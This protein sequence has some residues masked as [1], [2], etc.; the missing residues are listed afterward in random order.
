MS[1]K[2]Q[3]YQLA[4]GSSC[5]IPLEEFKRGF[6][7]I[8]N[9]P[10]RKIVILST[11]AI[12]IFFGAKHHLLVGNYQGKKVRKEIHYDY[13]IFISNEWSYHQNR[14]GEY[15]TFQSE[16]LTLKKIKQLISLKNITTIKKLEVRNNEVLLAI[17]TFQDG[18][19]L[20][21]FT[22]RLNVFFDITYFGSKRYISWDDGSFHLD[23]VKLKKIPLLKEKD[24]PSL[25]D[26]SQQP[27]RIIEESAKK[28][29]FVKLEQSL[30]LIVNQAVREIE[31][32]QDLSL[33]ICLGEKHNFV[34]T[35]KFGE[36]EQRNTNYDF[37]IF[38]SNDWE[39]HKRHPKKYQSFQSV[40]IA[41]RKAKQLLNLKTVKT[42]QEVRC[43]KNSNKGS[44]VT[45]TFQDDSRLVV[46]PSRG[47]F[48]IFIHFHSKVYSFWDGCFQLI[49]EKKIPSAIADAGD[50]QTK[51]TRKPHL[52][53]TL[54]D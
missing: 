49:K 37:E 26:K 47:N 7:P 33:K 8:L 31:V 29:S 22:G 21:I 19:W 45:F 5:E 17:L 50:K 43:T 11:H 35:D 52:Y 6:Q 51:L 38:T 14:D 53:W 10:I 28:I 32:N 4:L 40:K 15:Q 3:V 39:Y 27:Y 36:N 34:I 44:S 23:L 20:A 16:K 54:A 2:K 1:K 9:Y 42:I 18:S 41:P 24:C 25:V 30:Q 13:E 48:L 46:F 12:K